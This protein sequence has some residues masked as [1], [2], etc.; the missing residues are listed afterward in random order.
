MTETTDQ[1][2]VPETFP[3]AVTANEL[4]TSPKTVTANHSPT[5]QVATYQKSSVLA[6][7]AAERK[8]ISVKKG[9]RKRRLLHSASTNLTGKY[10]NL[11]S[12]IVNGLKLTDRHIDAAN[13]L[14]SDRFPDIQGLST[15]LLGQT[16]T[17][18]SYDCFEAAAGLSYVQVL[19]CPKNDHWLTLQVEFDEGIRVF[20]SNYSHISYDVKKQIASIV[21]S[22]H[23]KINIKLEKTQQQMNGTDCGIYAIAFATD[24]CH[25]NDPASLEYANG[26]QLRNHLVH[27][28]ENGC[29]SPFP[30]TPRKKK[31]AVMESV[32]IFCKCRLPYVLEHKNKKLVDKH[33]D[34]IEMVYCDCC[35]KWYHLSC[36]QVDGRTI[37]CDE[38]E[39][40]ICDDCVKVFDLL[41]D[42]ND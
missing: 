26:K 2:M 22:S 23:E 11:Y 38:E 21:K 32:N 20:D 9:A 37:S 14:L 28:F 1:Q 4:T 19:H 24:L 27:C 13:Q 12:T 39:E 16:L 18:P 7:A 33:I 8:Q 34:D 40:W 35:Q 41:S 29:I 3:T 36:L 6:N 42:D 10:I 25:G 17:F 30:S 31:K 15:P 5:M